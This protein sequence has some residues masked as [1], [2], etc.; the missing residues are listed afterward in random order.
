MQVNSLHASGRYIPSGVVFANGLD[1]DQAQQIV[2][3]DLRS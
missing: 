2:G 1:L 3:L